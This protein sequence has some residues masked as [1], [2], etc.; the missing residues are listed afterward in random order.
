MHRKRILVIEDDR[1]I[2]LSLERTFGREGFEPRVARDGAM[3]LQMLASFQ[4]DVVVLDWMLPDGDGLEILRSIR[5]QGETAVLFLTAKD[6]VADKVLALE[7]GADDYMTKPFHIRELLARVRSLLRRSDTG[8]PTRQVIS[9]GAIEIRLDERRASREGTQ[10]DLTRIEFDLL[11]HLAKNPRIVLTREA[12]LETVWGYSFEGYQRTVDTHI[13]RLR[14]KLEPNPE[15]PRFIH[16][17]RGVGYRFQD[18]SE[19]S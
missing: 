2:A 11:A 9:Q 12:L 3:G 5:K 19:E 17:V 7:T 18:S 15:E 4:P 14:A 10:L 13:R 1:S 6:E 8:R 16:T